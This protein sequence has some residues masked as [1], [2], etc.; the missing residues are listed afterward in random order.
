MQW[1]CQDEEDY[2]PKTSAISKGSFTRMFSNVINL[3][4]E[5]ATGMFIFSNLA[6]APDIFGGVTLNFPG[7][8]L[9][10]I[11]NGVSLARQA[12]HCQY[13]NLVFV[14]E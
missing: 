10:G 12:I 13:K 8:L 9:S 14:S 6:V 2:S 7:F 5:Q 1:R 4:C 3:M 11:N